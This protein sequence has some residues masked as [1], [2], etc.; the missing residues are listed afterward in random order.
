M[1]RRTF[2]KIT[3]TGLAAT[4][5]NA[6]GKFTTPKN[7][8]ADYPNI[9]YILADDLGYG[10]IQ[11]LDPKN[12]KVPTPNLN[13][14]AAQGM[15]F[16]DA[17]SGSAVCSPTRYGL[18]TGRYAWRTRLQ[19]KVVHPGDLPLIAPDRL[20]VAEMLKEHG[21]DTACIGK[22][23]LGIQW[24]NQK[25]Y[26][27]PI[28]DGPT[29]HGFDYY[30]GMNA[31]SF[32][33]YC[34]IENNQILGELT[35]ISKSKRPG[36]MTPGWRDDMVMPALTKKAV[37]YVNQ[38]AQEK[39]PFFLY[40]ALTSPHD[41]VAPSPQ[42][43]GKSGISEIADFMMETDHAAGAVINAID[44]NQ[45]TENTLIIFT[46]DNGHADYTDLQSLLKCGHKPSAQYRGYKS[47]IWEGGHR[48]PFL[49]RWPKEI[50][51]ASKS[52]KLICLTDFM[53]TCA[54]ILGTRLPDNAAE[55]S[56]SI[57]PALKGTTNAPLRP[58]VV[59][60]SYYGKFS[61]RHKNWKLSFCPGSG[62]FGANPN[63]KQA[64]KQKL[65]ELQLYDLSQDID[66]SENLI[67]KHPEIAAK[68]Q[69]NLE[70]Y[71][72]KGRSTPGKPQKNDVTVKL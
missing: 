59:H 54:E 34:F 31:P 41:P 47:D 39:R 28:L 18:L 65:P 25:T 68:L 69:K 13:K 35:E 63:D 42:F 67:K 45:L 49:A 50:K 26:G 17:H 6:C 8:S 3:G 30:F 15:V 27:D 61:L 53:A 38:K 40:F 57:L 4:A 71:I 43:K 62:G 70:D 14:M 24:T 32:P 44:Q 46:A 60:H 33:P 12:A 7:R 52:D 16:T 72:Q 64:R 48:V 21:Y 19:E 29:S 36:P 58:D 22:W 55:D 1:N 2:I 56:V 66:E 20:T 51:P 11:Y 5:L 37:E 9:I 23:H 10:D